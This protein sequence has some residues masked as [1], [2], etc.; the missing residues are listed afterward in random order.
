MPILLLTRLWQARR[1]CARNRPDLANLATAFWFSIIAY[2]GTGVFLHLAFERY[3]W[4]LLA[5]AAA[6]RE[7]I[8]QEQQDW[9]HARCRRTW[10]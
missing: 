7:V 2:L 10:E 4:L 9:V 5:L 3:Y 1:V 8:R 6:A